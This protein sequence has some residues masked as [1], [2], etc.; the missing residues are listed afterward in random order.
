LCLYGKIKNKTKKKLA[1]IK[2]G[3]IFADIKH[4]AM[5]TKSKKS[6]HGG[7]TKNI[8][9]FEVHLQDS[10]DLTHGRGWFCHVYNEEHRTGFGFDKKNKFKAIRAAIKECLRYGYR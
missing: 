10:W 1:G 9:G 7:I 2:K 3:Y 5:K 4:K 8:Q 6:A